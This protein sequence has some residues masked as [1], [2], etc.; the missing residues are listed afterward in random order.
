MVPLENMR[1]LAPVYAVSSTPLREGSSLKNET[2][3]NHGQH[4][5]VATLPLTHEGTPER[6]TRR[7]NI[8]MDKRKVNAFI[9]WLSPPTGREALTAY[10]AAVVE[11]LG[12]RS[13][14]D[15]ARVLELPA[16]TIASWKL[17]G[18]VPAE[19]RGW[20]VHELPRAIAGRWI[21]RF[22]KRYGMSL[23]ATLVYLRRSNLDPFGSGGD[24]I[25]A[26]SD[27]LGGILAIATLLV[28]TGG[29]R[30]LL[31]DDEFA[32]LVADA[33]EGGQDSFLLGLPRP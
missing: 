2:R 6:F 8:A 23:Y 4:V 14:A 21:D 7:E 32:N 27:A 17:R 11:A 9:A 12:E 29:E 31:D 18:A 15:L 25:H 28:K 13:D 30:V 24:A 3:A 19:R 10:L 33:L 20:F 5:A 22:P 16:S 1:R 26:V